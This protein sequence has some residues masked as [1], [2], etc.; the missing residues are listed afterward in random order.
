LI[1]SSNNNEFKGYLLV[2]ISGILWGTI[3]PFIRIMEYNN[4]SSSLTSFLRMAFAFIILAVITISKYGFGS[5]RI[6][7]KSLLLCAILGLICHGI[8]NLFYS[9][10]VTL[11]GVTISAVLLNI[12]PV[13]TAMM[14]GLLFKEKITKGKSIVLVINIL[15]CILAATGGKIDASTLSITGILCGLASGFCYSMTAIIGRFLGEKSNAFVISTYS[16]M[17]AAIFLIIFTN[18]YETP[19]ILNI[20]VLT[21]G[22]FYALIPTAIAYIFYYK[23]VQLIT[24]ISKVPIIASVETV[25]AGIIGLTAFNEKMNTMSLLGILLVM[26]SIGLMNSKATTRKDN[27]RI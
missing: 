12:A 20:Y 17:F 6:D 13:F 24:E 14:S 15:G 2:F 22:F 25:I 11:T 3:G 21:T 7:K 16:Y 27:K 18:P 1:A 26:T 10:A 9:I 8:N 23:G 5:L 4:S 19:A